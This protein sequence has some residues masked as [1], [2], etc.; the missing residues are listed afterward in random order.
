[1]SASDFK[2]RRLELE[3]LE[4]EQRDK[5]QKQQ[6]K[7]R[8]RKGKEREKKMKAL[9]FDMDQDEL[10]DAAGAGVGPAGPGGA[11]AAAASSSS[12]AAASSADAAADAASS[13]DGEPASKRQKVDS[14]EDLS[15]I[16]SSGKDPLADTSFLPDRA[17]EQAE[18]ALRASLA[19][20]WMR[21]Q[22]EKKSEQIE[23]V[24]SYWD[25]TGHRNR[26]VCTKGSTIGAFLEKARKDLVS[27]FHELRGLGSESLI[28]VKEDLL[29]PH[30]LTFWDFITTQARGKSGPLFN[31]DVHDDVRM[32]GDATVEKDESHAGKIVTKGWYERNKANFPASRWEI[33]DPLVVRDKYT[34]KGG[35]VRGA[36]AK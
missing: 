3:T 12:T 7:E 30:H 4:K 19:E 16:V 24:Y 27:Q 20:D 25:G 8:K 35:E 14:A 18:L 1:M 26:I 11:K 34:I 31:F 21:A 17:R 29:I 5:E 36:N 2:A 33:Y 22:L 9:T 32:V 10:A 23:I 28:Y 6:E 15:K 13:A